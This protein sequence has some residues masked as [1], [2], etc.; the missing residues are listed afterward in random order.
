MYGSSWSLPSL[1]LPHISENIPNSQRDIP[2]H[3]GDAQSP[4]RF[5][6]IPISRE[7]LKSQSPMGHKPW[8]ASVFKGNV[9]GELPFATVLGRRIDV[10]GYVLNIT[11]VRLQCDAFCPA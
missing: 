8:L 10:I 4:G 1:G 5:G 9:N 11:C 2:N 6:V 3:R 7:I